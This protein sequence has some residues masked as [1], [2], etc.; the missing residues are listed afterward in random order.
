[1]FYV[2]SISS[3]EKRDP[4]SKSTKRLAESHELAE[5]RRAKKK[6]YQQAKEQRAEAEEKNRLAKFDKLTVDDP[7][8][9]T[10]YDL[11]NVKNEKKEKIRQLVGPK[12]ASYTDQVYQTYDWK[13]PNHIVKK[14]TKL[15]AIETPLAGTSYN[16]TYDDHQ[17]KKRPNEEKTFSIRFVFLVE[18]ELLR[19]AVDVE[20]EKERK[21]LKLQRQLPSMLFQS[22]T[23]PMKVR[24]SSIRSFEFFPF[25]Q[26]EYLKEMT[27]G[28]FDDENDVDEPSTSTSLSVGKPVTVEPKTSQQR[29]RENLQKKKD[30]RVQAE[31]EKR[32]RD[33]QVFR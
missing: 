6:K 8:V 24:F 28:L 16:P 1:M 20:L 26:R 29:N 33:H 25:V 9:E 14:P 21:E 2:D 22:E 3:R 31:K 7:T 17:V 18:K 4:T 5:K 27:A 12:L 10:N 32:I 19:K 30:A 13:V 11:W 23:G 15:P